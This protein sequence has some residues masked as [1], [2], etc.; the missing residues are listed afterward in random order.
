MV[1]YIL[2]ISIL[3]FFVSNALFAQ[4]ESKG[5]KVDYNFGGYIKTDFILTL[6]NNGIVG[7]NNVLRDIHLPGAIPV[8]TRDQNSTL[9]F[10][11]KESRFNFDVK[12]TFLGKEI[13][14]FLELDFLF[15]AQGDPRVS[16]SF[17]PR[18]RHFYLEWNN[19]LI[20]QTWS[21]F[22]IVTLPD[23]IDFTGAME[24]I[25]LVRQA[26]VRYTLKNWLFAVENPQTTLYA[27]GE[28]SLIT[29]SNDIFPDLVVRRNFS[30]P[31]FD[32]GIAVVGRALHIRD[33][34]RQTSPGFGLTTGGK[35]LVGQRGDDLR[36]VLTYGYGMGRYLAANFI[37][38]STLDAN[39]M[40][41]PIQSLNGYIA[42]NRMWTKNYKLSSS[43]SVSGFQAFYPE[44]T[45]EGAS[46][47]AFSISGNLKYEPFKQ[48]LFGL[49]Y[50]YA[51]RGVIGGASGALHRIQFAAKY[52][53]GYHNSS[54]DEKK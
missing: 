44:E 51:Y 41:N 31:K 35:V 13:H 22:M 16:S 19:L 24:G 27:N 6:Y 43:F 10:H 12:T 18:L 32:W 1:R 21:T 20:G 11:V 29:A 26:Q 2:H 14:G 40:L 38:S 33:S 53:F 39:V 30:G 4:E 49:E 9:D 7:V 36:L 34:V 42:Y 50:M 23:E 8:G 48:L 5:K 3:V 17:S 25:V 45:I 37:P 46:E 15:S 54:V 52:T 28:P 47:T